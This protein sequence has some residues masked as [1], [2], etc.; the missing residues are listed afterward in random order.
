MLRS[1]K[2]YE[3]AI[4]VVNYGK[5]LLDCSQGTSQ[6]AV[7]AETGDE[8][9]EEEVTAHTFHFLVLDISIQSMASLG[10]D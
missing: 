4:V 2:E 8:I 5:R 3:L 1:W 9:I 10:R 6:S 7:T